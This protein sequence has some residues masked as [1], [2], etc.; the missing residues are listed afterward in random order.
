MGMIPG[1]LEVVVPARDAGRFLGATLQSVALQ[2]V[3]PQAVTVVD[4]GSSDDTAAVAVAC[5]ADYADFLPIRVLH[6]RGPHGPS[7]AR[8]LAIRRSDAEFVA[9]LDA[10]DLLA[11]AHH[12]LLLS[13]IDA[14][15]DVVVSFGDSTE[16][17][18][19]GEVLASQLA[20]SGVASQ[21]VSELAPGIFTPAD[22]M[23]AALLGAGAF[24][25]S[26]CI[27][28]R[29]AALDAGL[30]DETMRFGEDTDLFLRLALRGRFAFTRV[31]VMHKREHDGN[32]THPRNT[33]DFNRAKVLSLTR[34][35]AQ[36]DALPLGATEKDAL[37]AELV[38]AID[39]YTYH[40][41]RRGPAS[42]GDALRLAREAGRPAIPLKPRHLARVVLRGIAAPDRVA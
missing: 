3:L 19:R 39:A 22:G 38:R 23:F 32:L 40:A 25:T 41:S 36:A 37:H 16:F 28:R 27:V 11:P 10:D 30:F 42:Y 31:T 18:A 14:A 4:D 9:L 6:N 21:P 17:N 8:N 2:Y 33:L 26:A 34:L 12:Q 20:K 35:S 1:T 24:G 29:Q 13:A 15:P 5:A 7:A